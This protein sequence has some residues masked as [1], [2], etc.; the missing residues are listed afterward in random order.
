[1]TAQTRAEW[2]TRLVAEAAYFT[3][4][5]PMAHARPRGT[6]MAWLVTPHATL[7]EASEERHRRGRSLIYAVDAS[8]AS[9][10][11]SEADVPRYLAMRGET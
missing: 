3:V 9:A 2:E 8:G 4:S 1:M 7:R 10:P 6:R 5:S 11:L